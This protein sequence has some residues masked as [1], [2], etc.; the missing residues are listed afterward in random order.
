MSG[1]K[2]AQ[3]RALVPVVLS[4]LLAAAGSGIW[5]VATL[6]AELSTVGERLDRIAAEQREIL[7][8]QRRQEREISDLD[9]EIDSDGEKAQQREAA[10]VA[11]GRW[12]DQAGIL[13]VMQ[14]RPAEKAR[15]EIGERRGPGPDHPEPWPPE[16]AFFR[17]PMD[18][19]LRRRG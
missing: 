3:A 17:S 18:S 11:P 4:A 10:Q 16:A 8:E 15:R 12:H 9:R 19:T 5:T 14:W 6:T 1:E 2:G 13:S 7:R